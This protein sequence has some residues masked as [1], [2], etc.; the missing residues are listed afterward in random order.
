MDSIFVSNDTQAVG[1]LSAL[2]A[3]GINVPNDIAVVSVDS[4]VVSDYTIPPLTTVEQPVKELAQTALDVVG[5]VLESDS[6]YL[7]VPHQL[8]IRRSCGCSGDQI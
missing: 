4:S 1:A 8:I 7:V 3:M 6:G 2:Y 5:G